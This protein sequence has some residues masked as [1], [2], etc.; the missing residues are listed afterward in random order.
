MKLFARL[1]NQ[2]SQFITGKQPPYH[3]HCTSH[4]Q[5]AKITE[6][7]KIQ[8]ERK[9]LTMKKETIK[10]TVFSILLALVLFLPPAPKADAAT[11]DTKKVLEV[12]SSE[13]GSAAIKEV[14]KVGI[15]LKHGNTN[16]LKN[17]VFKKALEE[18]GVSREASALIIDNIKDI[19]AGTASGVVDATARAAGIVVREKAKARLSERLSPYRDT[20]I[21]LAELL[22]GNSKTK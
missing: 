3:F 4:N 15:E 21:V 13:E 17:I 18:A 14:V 7:L 12:L 16:T 11:V 2:F 1:Y 5:Y 20:L 22:D 8:N 19:N 6:R 9:T 10:F